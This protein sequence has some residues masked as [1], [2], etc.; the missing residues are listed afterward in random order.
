MLSLFSYINVKN[1][2]S[3]RGAN[4]STWDCELFSIVNKRKAEVT[5]LSLDSHETSF[6]KAV[7]WSITAYVL[8]REHNR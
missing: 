1:D 4:V 8:I 3:L 7:F 6:K 5:C 2:N